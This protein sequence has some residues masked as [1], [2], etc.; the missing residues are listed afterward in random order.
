MRQEQ[1]FKDK[2]T[3]LE[4]GGS[5]LKGKRKGKRP[6]TL[7]KPLHLVMRSELAVGKLSLT[8]FEQLIRARLEIYALKFRIQVYKLSINRN[9]LHFNAV[10]LT[11]V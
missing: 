9:H 3:P 7:S 5:L 6:I 8:R 10:R 11:E 1:L 4:Y 2:K